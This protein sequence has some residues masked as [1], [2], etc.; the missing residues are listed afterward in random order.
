MIHERWNQR[1][2]TTIVE[3]VEKLTGITVPSWSKCVVKK[4]RRGRGQYGGSMSV[5]AWALAKD[6]EE[7]YGIYYIV[8][9]ILHVLRFTHGTKM[10]SMERK[11]VETFGGRLCYGPKSP[12]YPNAIRCTRTDELLCGEHGS[13][14]Q[15]WFYEI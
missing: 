11:I 2:L 6:N 15:V 12:N 13:K 8:H 4:V 14:M 1:R 9:E 10:Q 7:T 5:P 3:R